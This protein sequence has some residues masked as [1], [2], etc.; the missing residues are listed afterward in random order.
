[1]KRRVK[2]LL[3]GGGVFAVACVLHG[4]VPGVPEIV[5][6]A[7]FLAAYLIVGLKVL[8]KAI[9]NILA[10]S[11]FDEN[12]LMAI[13]SV[14]AFCIGEYPEAVAVMLFYQ[15]GELFEDFAVGKSRKSITDLMNIRPDSANLLEGD[16]VK[17]VDPEEVLVGQTILVRPGEKIPL[18]GEVVFGESMV[19]TAALTGESVPQ[20]VR[21]G[22]QVLSGC[23][24]QSGL[25]KIRVTKHFGESTVSKILDL[26]E[27]ATMKKARTENFIT[28]FAAVY[29]PIVVIAALVL[30]ILPPLVVP[31][32]VFSDWLYRALNFLVVS[33]PCALVISVPL[34]FFGGIGGASKKGILVKGSSYL[35]LM[36]DAEIAVMDKTG[37]LTKGVFEVEKVEVAGAAAVAA[38]KAADASV[39]VSVDASVDGV[40]SDEDWLLDLAAVAEVH[41]SHP[42]AVSLKKAAEKK[43]MDIN[44]SRISDVEERSG[45]GVVAL[46]DGKWS[47][48]AGNSKLMKEVLGE[49]DFAGAGKASAAGA[50]TADD[51]KFDD[52]GTVVYVAVD[53]IYAGKIRIADQI[54]PDAA[55]AVASL[56]SKGVKTVML[57]GDSKAA[58]E[59]VAGQLGIDEV[60]T[61]LL[62]GDKVDKVEDL[63]GK[64]EAGGKR[65]GR[66]IFVGDGINDAPVL[67]RAD[68]GV[69]MGGLGSD[70]AIEAADIVIMNDEPSKLA[71]IIEIAKKT[72]RIVHQNI[73]FALGVKLLVLGLSAFGYANMW[74]AVFADVGVSMLAILN[75]FRAM[76]VKE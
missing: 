49:G 30:A 26:V 10:G 3:L 5:Q 74:L 14:G 52:A 50:A 35:E 63:L 4:L 45:R 28:R 65:R 15:V 70:A 29:T 42:I 34:S 76:R 57:T 46:V 72:M 24:N 16:E 61:Q 55:D 71:Y 25:L 73:V 20:A 22:S 48:A 66:L 31:G 6:L 1:M 40:W 13:A 41:S 17:T 58:G 69:A 18:D 68:V 75:S 32:A 2:R 12:F 67:A 7:V 27:N 60:H 54:K 47:V 9:R 38:H 8:K 39:A 53:G 51:A 23:I 62:P 11:V 21:E 56:K 43:G 64:L 36:A 33:C 19:D 37:T 44:A 59:A